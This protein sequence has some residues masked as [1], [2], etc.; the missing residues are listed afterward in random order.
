MDLDPELAEAVRQFPPIDLAD[1]TAARASFAANGGP[2]P[3]PEWADD[4]AVADRTLPGPSPGTRVPVRVYTPR[5]GDGPRPAI[6]R[7]HGGS[8]VIGDLETDHLG[9]GSWA[10]DIGAIVVNVDYRLAPEAPYPAGV[11]DCYAALTWVAGHAAELGADP[12]RIAVA[13]SSAGGGL[14]AAVALMS[15]DRG[16]PALALQVLNYPA[17]DDRLDTPSMRAFTETPIFTAHHAELAWR[18]YLGERE[19]DVPAH[20]APA[21]AAD[22]TGLPPAL[23]LGCDFDPLRDEGLRYAARLLDAGVPVELHQYPGTVH[24]FDV[25]PTRIS[26]EARRVQ[27]TAIRRHLRVPAPDLTPYGNAQDRPAPARIRARER[28]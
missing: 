1:L 2:P 19:G 10:R 23:L 7:F 28:S 21:R 4:V 12:A 15:R 22:L 14:A 20:A 8:F 3:P 16:G 25:M 27:V 13:G 9:C 5:P 11:E 17:L 26:A 6:V 24:G 18:Y